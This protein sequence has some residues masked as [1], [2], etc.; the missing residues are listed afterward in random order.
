ML[1]GV[2]GAHCMSRSHWT[3]AG[4][5][6]CWALRWA[7]AIAWVHSRGTA[8]DRLSLLA[9]ETMILLVADTVSRLAASAA[10]AAAAECIVAVTVE[11]R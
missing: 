11:A 6:D 10:A 3:G 8:A 2:A 4:Q 7:L 9:E 1:P 5:R